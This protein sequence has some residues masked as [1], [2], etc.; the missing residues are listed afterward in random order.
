VNDLAASKESRRV[1]M[2]ANEVS[3]ACLTDLEMYD[4]DSL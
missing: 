3:N 4:V 2:E 1:L